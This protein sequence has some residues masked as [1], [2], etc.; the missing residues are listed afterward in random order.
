[1][2]SEKGVDEL[3]SPW[4]EFLREL[5]ESLSEPLKLHCIGGFV[6]VYFYGYSRTTGDIDYCSAVPAN[7]NLEEVAGQSSPVHPK[8][9]K[10]G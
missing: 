2:P 1:M 8:N 6:L 3:P 4:R 7:L 9:L 10:E 5:D